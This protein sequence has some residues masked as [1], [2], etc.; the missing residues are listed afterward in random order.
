MI[1]LSEI[2]GKVSK[3]CFFALKKVKLGLIQ[4]HN[5]QK[6]NMTWATHS[7]GELVSNIGELTMSY[8]TMQQV[9]GIGINV[10]A[11]NLPKVQTLY[12]WH[13]YVHRIW[14]LLFFVFD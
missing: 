9:I 11:P 3:Q 12:F 13:F 1:K 8:F 4:T 2:G 5:P 14:F 7:Q 6:E 10:N